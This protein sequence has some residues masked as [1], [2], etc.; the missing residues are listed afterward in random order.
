MRSLRH[1]FVILLAV[2]LAGTAGA[3]ERHRPWE[4]SLFG[5]Y[6]IFDEDSGLSSREGDPQ[7]LN[8]DDGPAF[9]LR[10]A[11]G[12]NR[13]LSL[14]LEGIVVPTSTEDGT[15][16]LLALGYRGS[17]LLHIIPSGRFRPFILAGWGGWH[18]LSSDE[19][20]IPNDLDNLIH[21]GAG[22]KIGIT[23]WFGIRIDGRVLFPPAALF[24][25]DNP[26]VDEETGKTG[27]DFEI[28]GGIYFA[29]GG[30]E[31][32]PP[33]PP[34]P[35]EAP[36]DRDGDGITDD[37]DSCPDQ[38]EDKD[39]FEDLDGCPED[40]DKDGIPD[41]SDKCPNEP[42][43]KD[44]FEDDDG[45]PDTDNDKD[46]IADASDKCPNEP[47]TVNQYQDADGC[48]DTVPDTVKKFTGV[49]RGINFVTG[50]AEI[51]RGS[52]P[53][54]DQAVLIL[55]EYPDV[56]LEIQGHTDDRGS[57]EFNKNLSQQRADAVK[58][59]MVNAGIDAARLTAVGYGE[60]KAI[61]TNRTAAGRAK[62]RR[63]E[64]MLIQ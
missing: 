30:A 20:V 31:P 55:K 29:F 48:P 45:C 7:G 21:G 57:D 53:V 62:N 43:D 47:E 58:L 63:T 64:F 13:W 1:A 17:L 35:P 2:A 4:V 28:L 34:P 38:P 8:P 51:T 60:D 54:L 33:P 40:N 3:E 41:E 15:A 50:S 61:A 46:G 52:R 18:G 19:D 22:V 14:E 5:G 16:D 27:L 37:S 49:I 23:D 56:K 10:L 11:Y 36:K 24:G 9:G 59:Y 6:H 32:A 44:G 42:E 26:G 25:E 12:F 39:G